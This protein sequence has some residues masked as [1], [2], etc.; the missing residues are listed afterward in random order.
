MANTSSTHITI[1][2]TKENIK[3]ANKELISFMEEEHLIVESKAPDNSIQSKAGY[4]SMEI[5]LHEV[6]D[7]NIVL[8]GQGRWCSPHDY[9]KDLCARYDLSCDYTD[10]EVGCN[11]YHVLI[12]KSGLVIKDEEYSYLSKETIALEGVERYIEE[13]A[14]IA[15]DEDWE[16]SYKDTIEVFASVGVTIEQLKEA[17]GCDTLVDKILKKEAMNYI[18]SLRPQQDS[19]WRDYMQNRLDVEFQ[20]CEMYE[21][22][23][24]DDIKKNMTEKYNEYLTI[25]NTIKDKTKDLS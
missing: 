13:Y 23:S 20:V 22:L 8:V 6:S 18:F 4:S 2:G 19:D 11:F 14:Y 16:E 24:N 21:H 10:E 3:K 25:Y 17:W 5:N 15:E 7:T 9:I 1:S 12:I